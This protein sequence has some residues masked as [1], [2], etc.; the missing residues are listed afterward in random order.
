MSRVIPCLLL[1]SVVGGCAN[2][3]VRHAGPRADV[4]ARGETPLLRQ[5]P[6]AEVGIGDFG[7]QSPRDID[8]AAGR[9]PTRVTFAPR[10]SE[11]NLCNIHFHRNAEH[12]G[13]EFSLPAEGAGAG[14]R[15]AGTLAAGELRA[16]V[17]PVCPHGADSLHS[18]DTVEVHFVYSN[19]AVQPG[20]TLGACLN[21]ANRNP[22][23][24]VEAQVFVLVNA[25]DA[26]DFRRLAA[27]RK[28]DGYYQAPNLPDDTGAP[29]VYAGSTT[30]PA[31]REVDSPFQVTWAVRPKVARLDIASM[32]AWCGDNAFAE[33]HAH[34]VRPLVTDPQRLAPIPR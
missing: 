1:A 33:D 2:G 24:R 26:L 21:D 10:S 12:A 20:P 5:A 19:A 15:Y 16:P 13:G 34:G 3:P 30:G 25:P 27:W 9:N 11:M 29:V 23:L 32:G 28:I 18:G 6:A 31:Y 22:Q 17:R 14:Y 4:Q 8:S 7:P